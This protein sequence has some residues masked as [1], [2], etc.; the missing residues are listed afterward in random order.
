MT[1][2][3]PGKVDL[4]ASIGADSVIDYTEADFTKRGERYDVIIEIGGK[5]SL[6]RCRAA[7]APDGRLTFV[8]AGS[9]SADRLAAF[10]QASFHEKVLK[11]PV[12][13]FISWGSTD[14]LVTPKNLVEAG[15]LTP[16][17]IERIA[18]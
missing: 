15:D 5:L 11:H 10:S 1:A 8:G 14:D 4:I 2:T 18:E 17:S 9:G 3:T 16:A 7:L 13:A 12:I 6:P